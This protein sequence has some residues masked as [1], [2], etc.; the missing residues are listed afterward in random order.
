ML[1]HRIQLVMQ[2]PVTPFV[3][4]LTGAIVFD[5]MEIVQSTGQDPVHIWKAVLP[6]AYKGKE[7]T[8]KI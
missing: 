6:G 1:S 8:S 5:R 3:L 7:H 2:T 4:L